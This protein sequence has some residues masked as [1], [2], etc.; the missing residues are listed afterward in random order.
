MN[1]PHRLLVTRE[2]PS[3]PAGSLD[4]ATGVWTPSG[5]T[6]LVLYDG[7]ADAQDIGLLDQ[8]DQFAMPTQ[9]QQADISCYLKDEAALTAILDGDY[10]TVTWEDGSTDTYQVVRRN[11]LEGMIRLRGIDT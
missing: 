10:A 2:D 8:K 11:R 1:Y 4:R 5:A 3:A 9:T 7:P 6:P